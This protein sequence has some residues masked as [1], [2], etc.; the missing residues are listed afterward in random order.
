VKHARHLWVACTAQA[1]ALVAS[2]CGSS[3]PSPTPRGNVTP[4]PVNQTSPSGNPS[5]S[6]G[7]TTV[8]LTVTAGDPSETKSVTVR[9][10]TLVRV[11]L[12]PGTQHVDNWRSPF[13]GNPAVLQAEPTGGDLATNGLSS[14]YLAVRQ[15]RTTI[16]VTIQTTTITY[17]VTVT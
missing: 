3:S 13:V 16:V 1:L 14:A 4:S 11:H 5:T 7:A 10:G 15:G 6:P 2:A 8:V 12:L 17:D 9:V